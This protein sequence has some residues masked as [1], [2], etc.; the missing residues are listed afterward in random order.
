MSSLMEGSLTL[1]DVEAV[2]RT[3]EASLVCADEAL[4]AGRRS[5]DLK[6][7]LIETRAAHLPGSPPVSAATASR[8]RYPRTRPRGCTSGTW[9]ATTSNGT[10]AQ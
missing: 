3:G 2:A 1:A 9:S 5:R 6:L 7:R 10:E 8:T 4:K